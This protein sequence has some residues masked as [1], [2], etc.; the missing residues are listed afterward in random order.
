ME[1]YSEASALLGG[2]MPL[3]R[4][5]VSVGNLWPLMLAGR[6]CGL[7]WQATASLGPAVGG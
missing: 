5:W 2:H 1:G 7:L 6:L 3:T 4:C